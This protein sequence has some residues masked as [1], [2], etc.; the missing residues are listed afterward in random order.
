M[1]N[2]AMIQGNFMPSNPQFVGVG[3]NKNFNP[4][5]Q[6]KFMPSN[7]DFVGVGAPVAG[8]ESNIYAGL[9]GFKNNEQN[10]YG[11]IDERTG[12]PTSGTGLPT[13]IDKERDI[14]KK[15][16]KEVEN[17]TPK[18]PKTKKDEKD[19]FDLDKYMK[20]REAF[21][22]KLL[23]QAY[24]A[25]GMSDAGKSILEG[26]K[27]AAESVI[28]NMMAGTTGLLASMAQG[29]KSIAAA[30]GVPISVP[31]RMGYYG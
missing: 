12:L 11:K 15:R 10:P 17:K 13:S 18:P 30:F 1:G 2:M 27:V 16:E 7:P 9:K 22:Q 31:Q 25:G 8:P 28:P 3:A 23:N 19:P 29:N 26:S 4:Y 21:Q 20:D 14:F 6:G 5:I 24:I